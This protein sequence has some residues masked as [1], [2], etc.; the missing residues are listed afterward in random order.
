[1][2]DPIAKNFPLPIAHSLPIGLLQRAVDHEL[3][4]VISVIDRDM[5][6]LYVNSAFAKSFA[7]TPEA[8][9][10]KML[11][12]LYPPEHVRDFLPYLRRAFAGERVTYDRRSRV[13]DSDG[14]WFTVALMPWRNEAGEVLGVFQSSMKV[15][16]LKLSAEALRIANERLSSHMDNSPLTVL[17]LDEQLNIT[18]CSSRVSVMLG[19]NAQTLVGQPLIRALGVDDRDGAFAS[20]FS[21]LQSGEETRN[22][23][24]SKLKH[25]DGEAVYCDWFNSAL[26]D[27]HGKVISIMALVQDVSTRVEAAQQLLHFATHDPLTGLGNRRVLTERLSH[28]LARAERTG[29]AVALL[30]IDLDGFKHVN[31]AFG[32][33]AGDEVLCE[34]AQRL[35]GLTRQSD[36]VAR[37]GGD[38]FVILLETDVTA[39]APTLCAQRVFDALAAPIA[40]ATGEARVGASIGI[41]MHPPLSNLAADLI[42][43]ADAAMYTAKSAGKG[44]VRFA[45]A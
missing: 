4:T 3:S 25:R 13:V 15:H 36:F 33:A 9:I 1:M 26:T 27:A 44:C 19:H 39:E 34:V 17:E 37:I 18:H 22:R 32:H 29:E 23:V 14:I 45:E 2:T 31:D 24:E 43:R 35:R 38:E 6:L 30:F 5:R 21:R 28:A 40:F 11:T 20:A 7:T 41:A 12:E 16:E 10:G 8:L 42:R